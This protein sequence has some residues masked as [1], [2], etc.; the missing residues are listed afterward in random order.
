MIDPSDRETDGRTDGQAIAYTVHA[1]ILTRVKILYIG[2]SISKIFMAGLEPATIILYFRD[3]S[4][5]TLP[6]L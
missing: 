5:S 2:T 1:Y 3:F 4:L 6:H